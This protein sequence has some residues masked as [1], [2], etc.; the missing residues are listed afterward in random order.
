MGLKVGLVLGTELE[1][2]CETEHGLN[3]D[4]GP[5]Q[6]WWPKQCAEVSWNGPTPGLNGYW[7]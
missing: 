6:C 5:K 2:G 3:G 4:R 1:T 7:N